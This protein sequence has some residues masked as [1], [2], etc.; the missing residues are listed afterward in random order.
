MSAKHIGE[1]YGTHKKIIKK[2]T[3]SAAPVKSKYNRDNLKFLDGC[4]QDR[5]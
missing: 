3:G 5:R 2:T 1:L 4:L